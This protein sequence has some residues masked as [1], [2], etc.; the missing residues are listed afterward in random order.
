LSSIRIEC[1]RAIL[2]LHEDDTACLGAPPEDRDAAQLGLGDEGVARKNRGDAEDVEPAHVVAGVDGTALVQDV[3][4]AMDN[5]AHAG[6]GRDAARPG[7][8]APQP[9]AS[10]QVFIPEDVP[11]CRRGREED[12]HHRNGEAGEEGAHEHG[13][14]VSRLSDV[15]RVLSQS[16][17]LL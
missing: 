15:S 3:L 12:R 16:A 13:N 10:R 2:A 4:G 6:G 8:H 1:R 9:H 14:L 7:A 5:D 17:V 11:D